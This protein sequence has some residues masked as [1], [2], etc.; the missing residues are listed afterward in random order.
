M[1]FGFFQNEIHWVQ[2]NAKIKID[3][4][5]EIVVPISS[6][7]STGNHNVVYVQKSEKVF[8]PRNVTLGTKTND[9]VQIFSGIEEGETVVTSGGY[10]L[11]SESQLQADIESNSPPKK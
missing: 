7:I 11:D 8:E 3:L 4:E 5:E 10:L 9:Y 6:I 1:L 2:F